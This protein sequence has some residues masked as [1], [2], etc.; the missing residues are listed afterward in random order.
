MRL[1]IGRVRI[2]R[3]SVIWGVGSLGN[4][5]GNYVSFRRYMHGNN[6]DDLRKDWQKV[7]DDMQFA[8]TQM[9]R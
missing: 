7:G 1:A 2:P 9:D 3:H 4:I 5:S 8:L 6:Y